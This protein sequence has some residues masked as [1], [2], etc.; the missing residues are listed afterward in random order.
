M[1][2]T[3]VA[4]QLQS[5]TAR[6]PARSLL[7]QV[8]IEIARPPPPPPVVVPEPPRPPEPRMARPTVLAELE[9]FSNTFLGSAVKSFVRVDRSGVHAAKG[10]LALSREAST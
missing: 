10:A 3:S 1:V 2:H 7:S 9:D 5:T 4:L 6:H 8:D